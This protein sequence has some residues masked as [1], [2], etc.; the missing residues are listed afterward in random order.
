MKPRSSLCAFLLFLAAMTFM[1]RPASAN[2]L[3][4]NPT[5]SHGCFKHI[6]DAVNAASANDIIQVEPGTYQEYVTIGKPLSLIG[7]GANQPSFPGFSMPP[8]GPPSIPP[9]PPTPRG[10]ASVVDAAGLPHGFFVDGFDHAGLNNVTIAGFTV[11][12]A[13]FEGILV[14]SASDVTISNNNISN[15]DTTPGLAFTGAP[16]G[17]PGQPGDGTYEDDET[18]DCGGALHLIAAVDSIVSGN[19]MTGNAD[20][21][22]ISDETGESTG[23]L[24]IHNTLLNNPKECGIVLASHDPM[25]SSPPDFAPHHGV[26]LNTVAQNI[27]IGNGVQIG[28]SG[29][30]L[31]S[32][33][34]GPGSVSGNVVV[35]NVLIHNGLGGVSLHSHI[36]PAFGTP[37]DDMDGNQI[38]GN[39]IADNLADTADTATPGTVGI[40]INSGGGGSPV[41]GTIITLNVIQDEDFDVAVNTPAEVDLHLDN[42]LGGK[43]GVANVCNYDYT[44]NGF[45]GASTYCNGTIDATEDFWGCATGPGSK[46]GCSSTYGANISFTPWLSTPAVTGNQ[47]AEHDL[48][49]GPQVAAILREE[50]DLSAPPGNG[51]SS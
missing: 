46:G 39:Y 34:N 27:S 49:D 13:L 35:G 20:G 21:I 30:G 38:I 25:G 10:G 9:L 44:L 40:N 3:C 42:L 36:G 5:G 6:Q 2:T 19:F 11:E 24:L 7:A 12:N 28:G 31:F 29:V 50:E 8:F 14:V 48:G 37:A 26:N 22:L 16:T 18:G 23:N 15:N 17:C 41:V 33:G 47:A 4:V 1:G 43:V 51:R 45:S 32:D